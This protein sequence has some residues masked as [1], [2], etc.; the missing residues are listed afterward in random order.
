MRILPFHLYLF[1]LS[2]L[3]L[4]HAAPDLATNFVSQ[5]YLAYDSLFAAIAPPPD[6][7]FWKS[8][9][10]LGDKVVGYITKQLEEEKI[11]AAGLHIAPNSALD[12][13]TAGLE[14]FTKILSVE[15]DAVIEKLQSEL[16]ELL[17]EDQ[18]ERS[19]KRGAV[20]DFAL[21]KIEDAL[22]KAYSIL[23]I[24]EAEA[25]EKFSHVKPH[26]R[27]VV[28]V[29]GNLADHHPY[30]VDLI[31]FTGAS[32]LIPEG[33]FL[34]PLLRIFGFGTLG[35]VK[36]SPA[37]WAQRFFFNAA[38]KEGSWFSRLQSAGMKWVPPDLG[39]K[40][41]VFPLELGLESSAD[42]QDAVD[43]FGCSTSNQFLLQ[44]VFRSTLVI[45]LTPA[46][47]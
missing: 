23:G 1:L 37:A 11:N 47:S 3:S 30:V 16:S 7:D 8:A 43:D 25:R 21:D 4:V 41:G 26:I 33:L 39:K 31:L 13:C 38:V 45:L 42:Y 18:T 9:E 36:G 29:T 40:M 27:H 19:K 44:L 12:N 15:I 24:A 5:F 10:G 32:M 2:L 28:L 34:R 46:S 22:V 35:P 20:V 14:D 6:F 17:P